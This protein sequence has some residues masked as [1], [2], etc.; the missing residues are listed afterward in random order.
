MKLPSCFIATL[1]A[2]VSALAADAPA[3]NSVVLPSGANAPTATRPAQPIS[4]PI[5]LSGIP[6]ANSTA[7][8]GNAKAKKPPVAPSGTWK[9]TTFNRSMQPIENALTLS[10]DKKGKV[11]G[12]LV[13]RTGEHEIKDVT[14][15]D[16]TV[17]FDVKYHTRG[18][19]DLP[20]TYTVT[21]DADDAQVTVDRPDFTPSGKAKGGK[22]REDHKAKHADAN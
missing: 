19:G 18:E 5:D 11:T 3:P 15:G 7:A 1:L 4:G 20:H 12:K 8:N 9:W 14:V 13:D 10:V 6:P 17:T 21:L 2:T 22:H 16:G